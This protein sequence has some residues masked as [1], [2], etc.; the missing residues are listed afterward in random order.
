MTALDLIR[1]GVAIVVLASH[2]P[3]LLLWIVIH[4]LA[5]FWRKL[6]PG[7]TCVILGIP[8]IG[9]LAAVLVFRK[10]L[11]GADWG[12]HPVTVML[13]AASLAG[14]FYLNRQ[15]FKLLNLKKLSGFPE[16]SK[17]TYPGELLTEGVYG[18]VRNP[19]YIEMLLW[20]LG[21]SFFADYSG[22]YLVWLISLPVMYLVVIL[23]ERELRG[24]F[25]AAYEEYCRKVPRFFPKLGG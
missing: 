23:E 10:Y 8:V 13:A 5:G 20:V 16:L 14:A 1:Y 2:L 17:D 19:R 9:Y 6:G 12:F 4:P 3:S 15:R 24:R 21:Y 18:K 11:V 22:P 25:G 7:A